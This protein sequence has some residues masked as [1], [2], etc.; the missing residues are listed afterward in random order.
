MLT[1]EEVQ[2][3]TDGYYPPRI[4]QDLRERL[5]VVSA[6]AAQLQASVEAY[7]AL[8]TTLLQQV[9]VLVAA[10]AQLEDSLIPLIRTIREET[11]PESASNAQCL[12]EWANELTM[13]MPDLT[14]IP[15]LPE[16]ETVYCDDELPSGPADE[17]VRQAEEGYNAPE[18]RSTR[19]TA[20]D[21]SALAN[22]YRECTR[23]QAEDVANGTTPERRTYASYQDDARR[24]ET[25]NGMRRIIGLPPIRT[26]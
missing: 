2:C 4:E 21:S 6:A 26:L 12:E 22:Y 24:V 20:A 14:V 1:P 17:A 23:R 10:K 5:G 18:D 8:K 11:A 16:I 19:T 13:C 15:D 9:G 25:I 7:N 3:L